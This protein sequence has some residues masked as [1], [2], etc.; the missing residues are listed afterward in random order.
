MAA[1]ELGQITRPEA[2]SFKGSKRLFVVPLLFSTPDAP[3]GYIELLSRY[4][5]QVKDH[6]TRLEASAGSIRRVYHEA[7]AASGQGG[8]QLLE[9]LNPGSFG[10][11]SY[12]CEKGASLEALDDKDLNDEIM[13]W[14]RFL[15]TGFLSQKVSK[16]V[17]DHYE[18]ASKR[19]NDHM[20][21]QIEETLGP[22]ESGI[23]F[24]REGH[25]LQFPSEVDVFS[26]SP[27]AL[28]EIYRWVRDYNTQKAAEMNLKQEEA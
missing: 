16:I 27:P 17:A 12:V 9:K 14:E 1:E 25:S 15:M 7:I 13:D 3:A 4:W 10:I 11:A 5:A 2:S 22:Q 26:V 8:L 18:E 6:I 23:L 20:L 19:R 21:R 28:D 24:I